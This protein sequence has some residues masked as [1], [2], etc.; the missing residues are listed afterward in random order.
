LRLA[1]RIASTA[2]DLAEAEAE[3]KALCNAMH[4]K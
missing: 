4:L 2:W 1:S 3:L